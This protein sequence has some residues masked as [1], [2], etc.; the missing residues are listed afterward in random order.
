MLR[1]IEWRGAYHLLLHRQA[2][3][4]Q[5]AEVFQR[6]ETDAQVNSLLYKVNDSVCERHRKFKVGVR[7]DDV[8]EYRQ[9]DTATI[10]CRQINP[11][12][13]AWGL[14]IA[15]KMLSVPG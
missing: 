14:L 6:P 9:Y 13:A 7:I 10:G 12:P 1:E 2:A 5:T 8:Q 4:H 15:R 3:S 11:E